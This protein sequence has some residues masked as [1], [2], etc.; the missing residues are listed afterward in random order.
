MQN[1]LFR[2]MP[3]IHSFM[4]W[5]NNYLLRACNAQSNGPASGG[6]TK[7]TQTDLPVK[8][9][10][11][12]RREGLDR[13]RSPPMQK[14][15]HERGTDKPLWK[16]K[17]REITST[18]KAGERLSGRGNLWT[19]PGKPRGR[20]FQTKAKAGTDAQRS[21][22]QGVHIANGAQQVVTFKS[23]YCTPIPLVDNRGCVRLNKPS[24][25]V[26]EVLSF[27][28]FLFSNITFS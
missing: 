16:F 28:K 7:K 9:S 1:V 14:V 21:K 4:C 2:L 22:G 5:F 25:D 18:W 26:C 27:H 13:N 8:P 10:T 11:R 15:C 6:N 19:A 12:Q 17:G 20:T 24:E 23:K 3:F